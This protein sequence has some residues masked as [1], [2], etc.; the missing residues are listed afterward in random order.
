M[1]T[2]FDAQGRRSGTVKRLLPLQVEAP[3]VERWLNRKGPVATEGW[4]DLGAHEYAR[5]FTAA[6]TA[7]MDVIDDIYFAI[8]DTVARRGT[9][10]DFAGLVI[11]TLKAK[12]WLGG[13]EGAIATRV[14]L[15]YDTN[16]RLARAAGRW[17]RVQR[18]ALIQPY[19]RAFTVQDERV[20]RPPESPLSDHRAWDGIVLPVEHSFWKVYW[21]PLG[22]RCR[23]GVEQLSRSQL[24]RLRL[25]VTGEL[26]LA[27]RRARLGPPVFISPAAPLDVTLAEMVRRSNETDGLPGRPRVNPQAERAKAEDVFDAIL[28]AQTI[29][30]IGRQL[31][32]LFRREGEFA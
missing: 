6:R 3:D 16:L 1:T 5:A 11:P 24:A 21:P 15:I 29:D 25:S 4:R 12:G 22:F 30:D 17:D 9:E 2:H 23:C 31:D 18:S 8:V 19:L 7:G 32:D 13:D 20:R 10:A 26:E 28:R 27:D 14:R